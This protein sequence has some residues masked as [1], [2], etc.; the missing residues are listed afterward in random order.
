MRKRY[1]THPDFQ[2]GMIMR[3]VGGTAVVL[4]GQGLLSLAAFA[5]LRMRAGISPAGLQLLRQTAL[6]WGYV[7]AFI[8]LFILP[9]VFAKALLDSYRMV[10]G[11]SR[12]EAWLERHLA[13]ENP[14][15]FSV[16]PKD[17]L[18]RSVVILNHVLQRVSKSKVIEHV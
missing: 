9:I 5:V 17:D 15:R 10:G 6:Q 14:R 4:A 16:R 2:Y 3:I 7:L 13:G 12:L 1:I 18:E 11:L 8:A